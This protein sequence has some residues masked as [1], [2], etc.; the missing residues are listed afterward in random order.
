M[1]TK[2]LDKLVAFRVSGTQEAKLNSFC[3][4]NRITVSKLLRNFVEGL[5]GRVTSSPQNCHQGANKVNP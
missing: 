5:D 4:L 3:E 1:K 2:E